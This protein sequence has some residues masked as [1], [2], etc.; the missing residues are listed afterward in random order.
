MRRSEKEYLF[1]TLLAN[2]KDR[3]YRICRSWLSN[4]S[5]LPDL[6]QDIL[7][8]I[9]RSLDRFRNEA[10]L[11]TY[12][13][14][15]AVNVAIKNKMRSTK[16]TMPVVSDVEIVYEDQSEECE[17]KE[18]KLDT[19]HRCIQ[20]LNDQDKMLISLVLEDL[21]YKQIAEIFECSVNVIGV[22]INRAKKRITQLIETHHESL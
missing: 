6:Y 8:E 3:I 17:Q 11:D 1:E 7:I 2:N 4:E 18:K 9:W 15:I 21:S 13:Y 5:D 19:M 20:M 14:R 16:S 12:I 10:S 22:K